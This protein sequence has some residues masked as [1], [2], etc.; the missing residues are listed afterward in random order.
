MLIDEQWVQL[1]LAGMAA[2]IQAAR[3]AYFASAILTDLQNPITSLAIGGRLNLR[4]IIDSLAAATVDAKLI[5]SLLTTSTL[6]KAIARMFSEKDTPRN[7]RIQNLCSALASAA[8]VLGSDV[9]M[10]VST[11]ALEIAGSDGSRREL[12]LEKMF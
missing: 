11:R 3:Q 8:K 9:A 6:N 2:Q 10:S 5:K 12:G 7:R 1:A 4:H